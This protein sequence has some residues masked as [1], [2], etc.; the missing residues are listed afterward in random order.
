MYT[1]VW[2]GGLLR[3]RDH[4][5]CIYMDVCGCVLPQE[6][7]NQGLILREVVFPECGGDGPK[8]HTPPPHGQEI[9]CRDSAGPREWAL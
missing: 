9:E 4:C 6:A 3:T 8:G 7:S 2:T 5:H 1:P